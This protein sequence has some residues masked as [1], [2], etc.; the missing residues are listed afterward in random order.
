MTLGI[1]YDKHGLHGHAER[2]QAVKKPI[3]DV[4]LRLNMYMLKCAEN[5]TALFG[6]LNTRQ[7]E[8]ELCLPS[9]LPTHIMCPDVWLLPLH[10]SFA[11]GISVVGMYA[12]SRQQVNDYLVA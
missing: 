7:S 2:K 3:I 4:P 9:V 12:A 5:Q 6:Y 11:I 1:L 8:S 10:L